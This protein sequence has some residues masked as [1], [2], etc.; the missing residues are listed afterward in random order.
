MQAE[1]LKRKQIFGNWFSTNPNYNENIYVY[2]NIWKK[3][4]VSTHI[5]VTKSSHFCLVDRTESNSYDCDG[6]LLLPVVVRKLKVVI[7]PV[8]V[9]QYCKHPFGGLNFT[10]LVQWGSVITNSVVSKPSVITNILLNQI[11]YI[12]IQINPVITNPGYNEWPVP[13]CSL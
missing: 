11:G 13:S 7:L 12:S 10:F 2:V 8:S 9:V 5:I 1:Y 4:K 3:L 6:K